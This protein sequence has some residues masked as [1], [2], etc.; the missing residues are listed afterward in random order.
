M[1]Q[2]HDLHAC[3]IDGSNRHHQRV[4]HNIA[5]R[6]A[7]V[8]GPFNNFLCHCK[9][10]VRI[11][12]DT[13]FIIGYGNHRST[14]F[15]DQR[16]NRFQPVFFAG[17]GID[18]CLAFVDSQACLQRSHDGRIDRDGHIGNRLHQ[19]NGLRQ[20]ARLISQRNTRVDIQHVRSSLHLSQCIGN[21]AAVIAGDH[22]G[23]HDFSARRVDALTDD[24]ER[25]IESNY[26]LPGRRADNG[27]CH[28]VSFAVCV[29]VSRPGYQGTRPLS[30]PDRSMISATDSSC[31]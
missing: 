12:R 7:V 23:R 29:S 18:Q 6:N 24:D 27:I 4:N 14:I 20:H 5:G 9:T 21:N 3:L 22:L 16:Q 11:L 17:H 31:R 30:T 10:N 28:V 26:N 1:N 19:F 8:G 2:P 15:F 25:A 13:G